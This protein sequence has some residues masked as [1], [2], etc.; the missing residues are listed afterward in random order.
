MKQ[1]IDDSI[2]AWSMKKPPSHPLVRSLTYE[3][4]DQY[5]YNFVA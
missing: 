1:S 2:F 3:D 4:E 5:H